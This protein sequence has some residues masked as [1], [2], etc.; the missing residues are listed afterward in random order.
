[1]KL[2]ELWLLI[3]LGAQ[4]FFVNAPAEHSFQ[5]SCRASSIS[6]MLLLVVI[7]SSMV[8]MGKSIIDGGG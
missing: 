5:N 1:M 8:G 7:N 4:Y 6:F 2:V 3:K